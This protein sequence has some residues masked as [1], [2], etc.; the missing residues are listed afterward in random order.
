M[1]KIVSTIVVVFLLLISFSKVSF[2][3][4]LEVVKEQNGKTCIDL[5]TYYEDAN[6]TSQAITGKVQSLDSVKKAENIAAF[7]NILS[8]FL[9]DSIFCVND[10]EAA[11][12]SMGLKSDGLLGYVNNLNTSLLSSLPS[13]NVL[14]HLAE[15]FVPGYS[16]YN[17]TFAQDPCGQ[18]PNPVYDAGNWQIW[19]DCR[20]QHGLSTTTTPTQGSCGDEPNLTHEPVKWQEWRNCVSQNLQST[21]N[22]TDD[23]KE[24]TSK[25]FNKAGSLFMQNSQFQSNLQAQ[26]QAANTVYGSQSGFEYLKN[27]KVDLLWSETR[28]I[29]YLFFVVAM[30]IIGFMIMFRKNLP[31]QVVVS[32]GN[33]IPRVVLSLVLV[34]FSFAISG[35]MLDMGR[36]GMLAINRTFV[37]AETKIGGGKVEGVDISSVTRLTDQALYYLEGQSMWDSNLPSNVQNALNG[38]E[39]IITN[40]EGL[41]KTS[42][43]AVRIGINL[44]I[45]TLLDTGEETEVT[46]LPMVGATGPL[47]LIIDLAMSGIKYFT[48]AKAAR[49]ILLLLIA[50]YASIRLFITMFTTYVKIIINTVIAPLQIALGAVPGNESSITRWFKTAASNVLVF[51]VIIAIL[52]FSKFLSIAMDPAKFNFFGTKG[53][54]FP[55]WLV[56]TKGVLVVAGYLYASNAPSIVNGFMNIEQ[57]KAAIG[58][59]EN[60]KKSASKIP[61]I[62]SMFNK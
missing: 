29:A 8:L 40:N 6:I 58:V 4:D 12:K 23:E 18:E 22:M 15:E 60:V 36:L 28:N 48:L 45:A 56:H 52:A 16:G 38:A 17:T 9:G 19:K 59:G 57:S 30:I 20:D 46:E 31:G 34:T 1:K 35:L 32:V 50:L 43:V 27:L 51:V 39:D 49:L 44:L 21:S 24:H 62:G 14:D 2:A 37:A 26:V 61:L 33:S 41:G 47:E 11:A 54:F 55:E 25:V 3:G 5:A 10:E 53:V 7:T 42:S 13:V